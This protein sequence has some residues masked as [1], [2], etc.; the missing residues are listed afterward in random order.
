MITTMTMTRHDNNEDKNN[1]NRLM[2]ILD[3]RDACDVC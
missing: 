3:E 1:A 2:T